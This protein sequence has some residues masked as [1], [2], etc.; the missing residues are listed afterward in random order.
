MSYGWND[1]T[2][3]APLTLDCNRLG[4]ELWLELTLDDR[5][6]RDYCNRLGYE[7]WL[8]PASPAYEFVVNCNRLGYELWL[9]HSFSIV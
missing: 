5:E 2:Y 8:E 6:S 9:E 4:Y 7:L 1:D 3:V